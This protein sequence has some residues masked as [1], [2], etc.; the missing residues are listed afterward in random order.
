MH[1]CRMTGSETTGQAL[2][3]AIWELGR[4]IEAQKRL[5]EEVQSYSNQP[6]FDETMTKMT[7]IDA[8]CRE[9]YVCPSIFYSLKLTLFA[10]KASYAPSRTLYG[11]LSPHQFLITP[12]IAPL[13]R[14]VIPR[15]MMYFLFVTPSQTRTVKCTRTYSSKLARSVCPIACCVGPSLTSVSRL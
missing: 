8:V 2:G 10:H 6:T 4:N 9:V 13:S 3:S 7:Y 14:S 12:L 11:S 5:R 15:K 1:V